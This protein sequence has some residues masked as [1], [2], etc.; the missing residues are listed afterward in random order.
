[1]YGIGGAALA[2]C[3]SRGIVALI[4]LAMIMR[5]YNVHL[6]RGP[7]VRL[8]RCLVVLR[9]GLPVALTIA[10]YAGVYV[11]LFALV[12]GQL[13]QDV[14]AGFGIGFNAF[15]SVSYPFV[16]GVAMAGASLVGRNLGAGDQAGA[17]Q[18]VHNVRWVGRVVGCSFAMIFIFGGGWIAP[19]FTDDPA[20]LAEALSYVGILGWSQIIISDEVVHEKV[21]FG[22]GHP[23]SILWIS[24]F[25]NVIR[26]PLG[27]YFAI[28]LGY[29]APGLWWM[30]NATT[31]FK[32]LAFRRIVQQGKWV[33]PIGT[34]S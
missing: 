13:G 33:R 22:A 34:L 18:A 17:W 4:G 7:A 14:A 26:I 30:I 27:W 21:L 28:H 11:G 23:G 1:G 16:L 20:V 15:E 29:G 31:V 12:I 2:T 8:S 19:W 3:L 24:M 6:F 10:I 32:A 9:Q 5:S 25:G